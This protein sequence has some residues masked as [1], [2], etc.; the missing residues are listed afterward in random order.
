[1]ILLPAA[2]CGNLAKRSIA[3][4]LD[5]R[6][7]CVSRESS[8]YSLPNQARP[9]VTTSTEPSHPTQYIATLV[10][11][12]KDVARAIAAALENL[13]DPP[14]DAL[15]LFEHGP[16]EARGWRIEA[17]FTEAPDGH[18]LATHIAAMTDLDVA[19]FTVEAVPD[20]NWVAVSQAALPPVAAGRFVVHGS[21]D[22]ARVPQGPNAILIDAGEAFGT[23]H[24]QTTAG[25]LMAIDRLTRMRAY[26]RVLDLGCGSGVLA[27]AVARM[28]PGALILGSDMD[29]PSV[30][31]ARTNARLNGAASRIRFVEAAG[32]AHPALRSAAPYDLIIANIL[33]RPLIGLSPSL[34]QALEPGGTLVLSGLLTGQAREITAVYR[35]HGFRFERHDRVDGWSTLTLTRV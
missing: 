9:S 34:A 5:N 1:M 22:T 6:P 23:A 20:I 32:L 31:V 30:E 8:R 35:A 11:A 14:P 21:H 12:D 3:G 16:V 13:T 26:R 27:I 2:S 29:A 17:Y 33:A 18:A 10:H 24:H 28:L 25:C 19:P 4:G 15:T 7:A